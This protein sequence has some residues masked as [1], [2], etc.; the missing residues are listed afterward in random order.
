MSSEIYSRKITGVLISL[1]IMTSVNVVA[2]PGLTIYADVA[3]NSV[4]DGL[5]IRSAFLGSYSS[6]NYNLKAG[7]QTNLV[8]G[9]NITIS[10]Y[11][12]DGSRE[13]KIKNTLLGVHGFYLWTSA[14]RILQQTNYGCVIS[15]NSNH[16]DIQIG[17]NSRTYSFKRNALKDYNIRTDAAKIHENYNLMYSFG[18]NLKPSNY[19][20]NAGLTLTNID[21]FMINQ[22]TN[23]YINLKGFYKLNSTVCLFA[24]AWYKNAGVTN[25]CSNYFGFVIRG[26]VQWKFN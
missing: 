13:F 12:I 18:Y 3:R 24:E 14:S 15:M 9:N 25:I 26:G 16:F 17:T 5:Y 8:N 1:L 7:L 23:P 20:W 2:Q 22:E 21:Y 11:L 4:S 19:K 10:G 6:G